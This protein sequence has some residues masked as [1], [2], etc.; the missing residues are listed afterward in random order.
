MFWGIT[1]SGRFPYYYNQKVN[2]VNINNYIESDKIRKIFSID[3]FD[4]E[5][6][7]YQCLTSIYQVDR[8]CKLIGAKLYMLDLF[9]GE[10]NCLRQYCTHLPNF[11]V[12]LENDDQPIDL[13]N[14]NGHPGPLQHMMYAYKFIAMMEKK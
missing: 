3:K 4:D 2:H 14:D 1:T 13:G 10:K 9:T 6:Q 8:Y 12:G 11:E 7:I 5:D